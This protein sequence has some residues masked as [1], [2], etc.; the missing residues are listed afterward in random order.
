MQNLFHYRTQV[1]HETRRRIM[2]SVWAYAYEFDNVSLVNDHHFDA[3]CRR[4]N[5]AI[6]T[7]RPALDDFF[8]TVFH[9]DTGMWIHKHPELE[10][11]AQT[12][13]RWYKK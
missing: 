5:P 6:S 9:P 1:E 4:I 8:R 3:E 11:V 12:Y 13:N 10:K 2:V 7:G